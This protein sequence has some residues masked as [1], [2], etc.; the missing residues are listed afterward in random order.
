[1]EYLVFKVKIDKRYKKGYIP[2][3]FHY[4]GEAEDYETAKEIARQHKQD[5][6]ATGIETITKY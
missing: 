3:S 5:G 2:T 1:M 4:V 6:Y